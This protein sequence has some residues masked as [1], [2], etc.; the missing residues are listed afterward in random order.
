VSTESEKP[1]MLWAQGHEIEEKRKW[2]EN[3]EPYSLE[4]GKALEV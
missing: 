2:R 3:S 1:N 4:S